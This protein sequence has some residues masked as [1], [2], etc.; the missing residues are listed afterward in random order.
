MSV[1]DCARYPL[2][3]ADLL[4]LM[5]RLIPAARQDAVAT[6]I[7]VRAQRRH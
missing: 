1:D 3:T 5:R 7:V 4:A 2:F 6:V